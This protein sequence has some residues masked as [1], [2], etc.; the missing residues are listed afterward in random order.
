MEM[1]KRL[2]NYK[3]NNEVQPE[4]ESEDFSQKPSSTTFSEKLS[5]RSSWRNNKP[6]SVLRSS[7]KQWKRV[8]EVGTQSFL[9]V[10]SY[11]LCM[12]W[13]II[14]QSLDG[15]DFDNVEGSGS[16]FL[17]LLILQ[18]IFLPI[19]GFFRYVFAKT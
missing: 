9:Y 3:K 19:Q 6:N 7:D 12:I 1:E 14:K 15:Q 17:P 5:G 11:F 10:G 8:K 2:A 16:V 13:T 4:E 18:S